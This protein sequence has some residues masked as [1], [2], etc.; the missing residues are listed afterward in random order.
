MTNY[1]YISLVALV[2]ALS[3][4]GCQSNSAQ[5]WARDRAVLEGSPKLRATVTQDCVKMVQRKFKTKTPTE[6]RNFVNLL[7]TSEREAPQ[8]FCKR[9]F[10][11]VAN[12]RLNEKTFG[13]DDEATPEFVKILQGR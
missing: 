12:G 5:D 8:A 4:A 11:A 1:N 7:N 10:A 2:G 6:V 9:F 3:V 13:R